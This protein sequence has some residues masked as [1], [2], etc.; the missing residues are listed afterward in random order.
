MSPG[1]VKVLLLCVGMLGDVQ[2]VST[3]NGQS[4]SSSSVCG[5]NVPSPLAASWSLDPASQRGN[6]WRL[7]LE[8]I[9]LSR[10]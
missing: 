3:D 2:C 1:Q 9:L 7:I 4:T 5:R 6:L 10:I 8:D